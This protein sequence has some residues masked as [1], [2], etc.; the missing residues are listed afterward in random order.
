MARVPETLAQRRGNRPK[1]VREVLP[2]NPTSFAHLVDELDAIAVDAK[3]DPALARFLGSTLTLAKAKAIAAKATKPIEVFRKGGADA[4][5]WL[6]IAQQRFRALKSVTLTKFDIRSEPRHGGAWWGSTKIA[7]GLL[8]DPRCAMAVI[9]DYK[10]WSVCPGTDGVLV[11]TGDLEAMG[12]TMFGE[13]RVLGTLRVRYING[14]YGTIVLG[15]GGYTLSMTDGITVQG[16]LHVGTHA[17][18]PPDR[19]HPNQLAEQRQ[20]SKR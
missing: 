2:A 16:N 19:L 5:A 11:V 1:V 7:R 15:A 18:V 3:T 17:K 13:L 14:S 10:G 4:M 8:V 9:G 20:R 6:A 12:I